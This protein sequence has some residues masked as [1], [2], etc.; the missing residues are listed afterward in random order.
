LSD[1]PTTEAA[2]I[3]GLLT[4]S[5]DCPAWQRD[6]LRRLCSAPDLDDS[7]ATELLAICK[8]A[9]AGRPLDTS[10]VKAVAAGNPVVALRHVRNV[11]HVNALAEDEKL[12]FTRTG[13]TVVYGDNERPY[14]RIH[15]VGQSCSRRRPSATTA[16]GPRNEKGARC[17]TADVRPLTTRRRSQADPIRPALR[18]PR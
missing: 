14:A 5:E 9:A 4:W 12:T 6:A 15:D 8:G 7:D 2:V 10:H 1:F 18:S 17:H 3:A 11:K 16:P 13:L